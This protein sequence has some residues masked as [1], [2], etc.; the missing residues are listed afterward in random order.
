MNVGMGR[1][2]NNADML[3]EGCL[4]LKCGKSV[5]MGGSDIVMSGVGEIVMRSGWIW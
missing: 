2:L 4:A 5:D 1:W 3:S